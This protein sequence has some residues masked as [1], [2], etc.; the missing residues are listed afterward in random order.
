MRREDVVNSRRLGG[1]GG[2]VLVEETV[3]RYRVT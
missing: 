3:E 2:R 1:H